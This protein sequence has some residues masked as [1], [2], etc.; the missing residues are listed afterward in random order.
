MLI[1]L[2][3]KILFTVVTQKSKIST[4]FGKYVSMKA[5]WSSCEK[6]R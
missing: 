6:Q 1:S 4:A 2:N 3:A 5:M